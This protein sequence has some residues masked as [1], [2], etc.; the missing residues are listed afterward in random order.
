MTVTCRKGGPKMK[1][2]RKRSRL[3]YLLLVAVIQIPL[4]DAPFFTGNFTS[5]VLVRAQ[6]E[7]DRIQEAGK[8]YQK[9]T[10]LLNKGQ[11]D[12]AL[13]TFEEVLAILREI[14]ER[15]GQAAT[16]N[17]I[18]QIYYNLG[19]YQQALDNYET[20][21]RIFKEFKNDGGVAITMTNMAVVYRNLGQYQKAL[22]FYQEALAIF[23]SAANPL[24]EATTI[25]NIAAVYENL[26][27]Y[28]TAVSYY[29]KALEKFKEMG[30]RR[31][32]AYALLNIGSARENLG[33]GDLALERYQ[34]ALGI[35]REEED[36]MGEG[37]T[38]TY[39]GLLHH[40]GD[41]SDEG[42]SFLEKA[43]TIRREIDDRPGEAV[44]LDYLGTVYRDR[45][46]P[47]KALKRYRQALKIAKKIG[48]RPGVGR[49]L[50]NIGAT[51]LAEG[52]FG[53]ATKN[54]TQA[55]EIWESLRPGLSD[56]NKVSLFDT[57][58]Q[59]YSDLQSALVAQNKTEKALEI[60]ER[61]RARAFAELIAAGL[62]AQFAENF[63]TPAPPTVKEIR[64]I[65]KRQQATLV[66]Y[67]IANDKLYIWVVRPDGTITLRTV[68]LGDLDLSLGE[69][70][71]RS[72]AAAVAG[73]SRSARDTVS[74]LVLAARA[75]AAKPNLAYNL[76]SGTRGN[77]TH[78]KNQR[79]WKSYNLLI[80]PIADLLPIAPE[81][82]V[83]PIPQS[84]LFLI[85]FA[86]LQDDSGNY[87]IEKHTIAIAP[88]IQVLDLTYRQQQQHK[89]ADA[90]GDILIVGN[91]AMPSLPAT[92]GEE[93]VPLDPLPHAEEEAK[94]IA[95]LL[96]TEPVLGAAAT[97]TAIVEKMRN[98]SII[99]LATHGQLD[100]LKD[101]SRMPGAIALTPT[102]GEDGF[103][104]SS[105]IMT[106]K[107]KAELVVISACNT[108][109]GEITG[110]GVIGLSR[111]F[112]A[113][114]VPSAMVSLWSLPDAPTAYL[115]VEFYRYKQRGSDRSVAL[116]QAMLATMKKYPH[117]RDW[118]GLI[119]LG[120]I[121]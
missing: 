90:S 19:E 38:L 94:A 28:E 69:T 50:S 100:E 102:D 116:R 61:G 5:S 7:P 57:Q 42:L 85:P 11:L 33:E 18:G 118:A 114:G 8:L 53:K 20:A 15:Q 52:K 74:N 39:I 29:Q 75:S 112:L 12:A 37:R 71:E 25:N 84:S 68:E 45:G 80:E 65:A 77:S 40:R 92:W 72:Q 86:A 2:D 81:S 16:I 64:E 60:A 23:R 121:D 54:L 44:T 89:N 104:T 119:L 63:Q 49:T 43:L 22:S 34:Q 32:Q 83:I 55:V 47:K 73:A 3:L 14:D 96:N 36:R 66:E 115:N 109:R 26:G 97:E 31:S 76:P 111:A 1:T 17:Q 87:L 58:L 59:T 78:I 107:L 9:A 101:L 98:A 56:E 93:P 120:A 99:H 24:A 95:Q 41:R 10:E 91:P 108:G 103:L 21:T 51:Y 27:R 13:A 106:M 113:A 110:D 117:P 70:V 79:L 35:M 48:D 30:D 82:P 67:S 62:G 46:D 105:E 88:S 6:T 4:L